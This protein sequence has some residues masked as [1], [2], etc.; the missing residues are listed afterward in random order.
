MSMPVDS[1]EEESTITLQSMTK[2]QIWKALASGP[3]VAAI[4]GKRVEE[5]HHRLK[6]SVS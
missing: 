1:V 2:A 6:L 5:N 3:K 4:R